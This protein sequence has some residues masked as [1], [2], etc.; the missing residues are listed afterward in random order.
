MRALADSGCCKLSDC[1]RRGNVPWRILCQD[2]KIMGHRQ[3]VR[4]R[5]LTPALEGSN[6]AG[7]AEK[8]EFL[9]WKFSFF[10]FHW[11][12][13]LFPE[14]SSEC[15]PDNVPLHPH[16]RPDL[17]SNLTFHKIQ[18]SPGNCFPGN[19]GWIQGFEPWASRATIWR[20]NQLRYTHHNIKFE[21]ALD[22]KWA[23]RDSNPRPTA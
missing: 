8:A 9:L 18:K 1:R 14:S 20:A 21:I 15:F 3:A 4:H 23:W 22:F 2:I 10:H 5:T 11:V 19:Y 13:F 16:I 7:P 17:P 6:P 12:H